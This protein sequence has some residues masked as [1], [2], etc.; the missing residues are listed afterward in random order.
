MSNTKP[1]TLCPLPSA[2]DLEQIK[3]MTEENDHTGARI[4]AVKILSNLWL[5]Q[6]GGDPL[7]NPFLPIVAALAQIIRQHEARGSATPELIGL[8]YTLW[9]AAFDIAKVEGL[10]LAACALRGAL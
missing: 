9:N 10:G 6:N 5:E 1:I 4:F 7:A 8:R 2:D 3:R